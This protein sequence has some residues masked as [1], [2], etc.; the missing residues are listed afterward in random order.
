[1][2]SFIVSFITPFLSKCLFVLIVYYVVV[3]IFASNQIRY[4]IFIFTELWC[5]S[6]ELL[7][8]QGRPECDHVGRPECVRPGLR[9]NP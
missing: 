2:S 4:I 9:K 5:F 8:N 7:Q 1:M 6:S 3:N